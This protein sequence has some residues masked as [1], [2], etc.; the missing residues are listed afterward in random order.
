MGLKGLV[1]SKDD[2]D[3]DIFKMIKMITVCA[4]DHGIC[5]SFNN[6]KK[7]NFLLCRW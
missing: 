5:V 6:K 4:F 2:E 3:S 7:V 1:G